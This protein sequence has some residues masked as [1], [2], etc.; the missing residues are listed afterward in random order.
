MLQVFTC[1]RRLRQTHLLLRCPLPSLPSFLTRT[2]PS[3]PFVI[4]KA[5]VSCLSIPTEASFKATAWQGDRQGPAVSLPRFPHPLSFLPKLLCPLS[6]LQA[7]SGPG[8][9][10]PIPLGPS[11]IPALSQLSMDTLWHLLQVLFV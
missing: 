6:G 8:N 9:T 10:S 4:S 3:V 1:S 11:P 7:G 2:K 5:H